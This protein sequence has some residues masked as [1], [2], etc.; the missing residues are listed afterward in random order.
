MYYKS[1]SLLNNIILFKGP[2]ILV[3]VT[4]LQQGFLIVVDRL[5]F[6][7]YHHFR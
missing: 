1:S 3:Y 7:K 5:N 4:A 2:A 6:I